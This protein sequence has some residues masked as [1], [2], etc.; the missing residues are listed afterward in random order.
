MWF[1]DYMFLCC[2]LLAAR[3]CERRRPRPDGDTLNI[4]STRHPEHPTSHQ[5]SIHWP[6]EKRPSTVDQWLLPRGNRHDLL[7]PWGDPGAGKGQATRAAAPG[8]P[9][10]AAFVAHP[11]P[12]H[13]PGRSREMKGSPASPEGQGDITLGTGTGCIHLWGNKHILPV[14]V[15]HRRFD[16]LSPPS[17]EWLWSPCAG[18]LGCC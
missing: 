18:P 9:A 10:L 14:P 7:L 8:R 3:P 16:D 13:L 5:L 1:V 4:L 15:P 12:R 17:P 11:L 2:T 6:L